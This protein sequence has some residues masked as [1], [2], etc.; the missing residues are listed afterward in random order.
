MDHPFWRMIAGDESPAPASALTNW[1]VVEAQP[2]SGRVRTQFDI[3]EAFTNPL[4][5]VHG[6]CIASM[7]DDT[8]SPALATVLREDEFGPTIELKLNFLRAASPGRF[9]GEGR[10]V[11]R[12]A[13][14]AFLEGSLTASDGRLVATGT[15]TARIVTRR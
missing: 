1:K 7:L 3:S 13:S 9:L 14:V 10:V 8:M 6:G 11:H 4:G 12:T 15:A 2:G 5:T